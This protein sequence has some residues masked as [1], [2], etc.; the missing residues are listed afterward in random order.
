[1]Y[2]IN[3]Q[4]YHEL[5]LL[6]EGGYGFVWRAIEAKSKKMCVLKKVICQSDEAIR[7]AKAELDIL[8]SFQD[9]RKKRLN[10]PNIV[11]CYN[12]AIQQDK[13]TQ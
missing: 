3:G 10:H 4:E 11:K 1:M 8:V 12:G 2:N 13:A 9:E 7:A 5:N 6:A